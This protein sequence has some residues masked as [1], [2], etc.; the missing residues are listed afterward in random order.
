MAPPDNKSTGEFCPLTGAD[1]SMTTLP[2]GYGATSG[3]DEGFSAADS[4]SF[5]AILRKAPSDVRESIKSLKGLIDE[6]TGK[7]QK[8]PRIVCL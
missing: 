1:A 2:L 5:R 6:H 7:L 4:P 3:N 8:D